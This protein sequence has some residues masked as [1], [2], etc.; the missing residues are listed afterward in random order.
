M[1]KRG[2]MEEHDF[3]VRLELQADY[4]AGVWAHYGQEQFKFIEPGDVDSA[5]QTANR[6][7]DNRLE[8]INNPNGFAHPENYT[9]GTSEQRVRSFLDGL[10]TGDTSKAKLD[11]FFAVRSSEDLYAT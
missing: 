11:H 5:I 1:A 4:L 3:S 7:G 2:T 10:R 6:I 9:H 8:K